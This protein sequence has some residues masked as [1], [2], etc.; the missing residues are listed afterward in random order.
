MTITRS[1]R[2]WK[3]VMVYFKK[4]SQ[5]LPWGTEGLHTSGHRIKKGIWSRSVTYLTIFGRFLVT[6]SKL[7]TLTPVNH[8]LPPHRSLK[9]LGTL[10]QC[11]LQVLIHL[12][13]RLSKYRIQGKVRWCE[14]INQCHG[15]RFKLGIQIQDPISYQLGWFWSYCI[16]SWNLTQH[17]ALNIWCPTTL[18]MSSQ[19]FILN[20]LYL[21]LH[22]AILANSLV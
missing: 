9:Y 13:I 7:G 10:E 5:H 6:N 15:F 21:N 2:M 17:C 4:L 22:I 16:T 12:P 19:L 8:I 11:G 1:G 20:R 18:F 3:D 14:N